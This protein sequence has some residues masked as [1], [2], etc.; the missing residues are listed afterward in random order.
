VTRDNGF[1][2]FNDIEPGT[3]YRVTISAQGFANWTSPEVILQPGQYMILTG[4]KL[5]IR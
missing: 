5:R 1:F 3:A 4:S 2:Q